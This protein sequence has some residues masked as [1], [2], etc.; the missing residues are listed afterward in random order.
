MTIGERKCPPRSGGRLTE[1][2]NI[3]S[4]S[5]N[6]SIRQT[7]ARLFAPQHKLSCSWFLWRRLLASLRKRGRDAQGESGAFLLGQR[8]NGRARITQFIL[9]DDLDP[10][11]LKT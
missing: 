9:Y 8:N 3:W 6:F 5:M 2:L 1:S 7:I 4:S 11:S 10:T